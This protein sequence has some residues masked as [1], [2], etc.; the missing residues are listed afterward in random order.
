LSD[1]A[2]TTPATYSCRFVV[3]VVTAPGFQLNGLTASVGA[4]ETGDLQL[5]LSG[6]APV[7]LTA[8]VALAFEPDVVLPGVTD[9]PLVQFTGGR[10][11]SIT[12]AVPAGQ[13]TVPLGARVNLSNIAG[14]VRVFV[15]SLLDAGQEVLAGAGPASELRIGRAPPVIE[16]VTFTPSGVVIRGFSN[17][18]DMQSVTLAFT[19]AADAEIEGA[20]TFSFSSEVQQYFRQLYQNRPASGGSAFEVRFPVTLTGATDGVASVTVTMRNSAGETTGQAA[21]R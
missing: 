7:P 2:N 8:I 4:L 12:V 18:L 9:N 21:L 15:S 5:V 6:P 14:T 16:S 13:T 10:Q 17:T 20:S 3:P 11:R 19:A 1:D